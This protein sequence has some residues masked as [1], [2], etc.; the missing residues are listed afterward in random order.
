M[1]LTVLDSGHDRVSAL[2]L[3]AVSRFT[4]H[5]AVDILKVVCY[6]ARF[7]GTPYSDLVHT[8]LR[9]PGFWTFGEREMFA[10]S[11]SRANACAFCATAHQDIAG[12]YLAPE[13]VDE[14]LATRSTAGLRPE[15]GAMLVFL[16]TLSRAPDRLSVTDVEKVRAAGVPDDALDQAVHIATLFHVINRVMNAVGATVPDAGQRMISARFVRRLGYRVP[17]PVRLLSRNG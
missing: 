14:A 15:A 4:R 12:S 11:V 7:F 17:T 10:A 6:R 5:E 8:A 3:R 2:V 1:R 9:G 16:D 13:F